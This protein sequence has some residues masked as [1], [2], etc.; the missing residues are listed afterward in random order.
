MTI[1]KPTVWVVLDPQDRQMMQVCSSKGFAEERARAMDAI[2]EEWPVD[3]SPSY[4]QWRE[5]LDS[6]RVKA[7]V[8]DM[9]ARLA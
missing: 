5:A 4:M 2:V 3:A 1:K 9:K 7:L 8:A 6:A